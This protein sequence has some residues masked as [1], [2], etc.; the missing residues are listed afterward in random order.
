MSQ[1]SKLLII[2]QVGVAAWSLAAPQ[3]GLA[4]D[5]PLDGDAVRDA[6]FLGQDLGRAATFLAP[7]TKLLPV[8]SSGPDVAQIELST[9]YAQVVEISS[10]H[11]VGYSAQQAA[12]D[13]RKRG[14]SILVRVEVLFTPTYTGGDDYWRGVSVGLIQGRQHMGAASVSG[15]PIYSSD[16]DGDSWVIGANVFV[17]FRIA[18]VKSDT[19]Q[20]EVEPPGGSAVH[21]SFGLQDLR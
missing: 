13:H 18:G 11:T 9:P 19:V 2:L 4:Y 17:T 8:P 21:A 7:Y 5:H 14:D 6:Y 12:E 20:V 10:Q 15:Q 3:S 16:A 1:S